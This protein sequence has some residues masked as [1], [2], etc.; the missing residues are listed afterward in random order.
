MQHFPLAP[1]AN[2]RVVP[3]LTEPLRCPQL[4]LTCCI[5]E[6]LRFV[7]FPLPERALGHYVFPS[8]LK[9]PFFWRFLVSASTFN[10]FYKVIEVETIEN[11]GKPMTMRMVWSLL[12]QHSPLRS[13][14]AAYVDENLRRNAV[15]IIYR[16]QVRQHYD[17]YV[18]TQAEPKIL[19]PHSVQTLNGNIT[20]CMRIGL[21][22]SS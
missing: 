12:L 14:A 17:R 18:G 19:R 22:L 6:L 9:P 1:I 2:S 20:V 13:K 21:P 10:N 15:I 7:I 8:V 16:R 11:A 5:N 4:L 3:P